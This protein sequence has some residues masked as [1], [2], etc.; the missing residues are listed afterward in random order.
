M[1]GFTDNEAVFEEEGLSGGTESESALWGREG[2]RQRPSR[3]HL[4]GEGGDFGAGAGR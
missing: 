3:G 4:A 1:E 2:K